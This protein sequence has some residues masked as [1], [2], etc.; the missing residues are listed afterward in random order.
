[1]EEGPEGSTE[2]GF[3]EEGPEHSLRDSLRDGCLRSESKTKSETHQVKATLV[4]SVE[5]KINEV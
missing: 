1:V 4:C 2:E 5:C 3:I